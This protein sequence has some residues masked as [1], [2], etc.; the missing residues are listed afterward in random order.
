MQNRGF[1]G[2]IGGVKSKGGKHEFV[3]VRSLKICTDFGR[4]WGVTLVMGGV[5]LG[6]FGSFLGGGQ[7]QPFWSFWV[8]LVILSHFDQFRV[9]QL[10]TSSTSMQHVASVVQFHL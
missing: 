8:I 5:F 2:G 10:R 6:H 9:K 4:K 7:K 1:S 3:I